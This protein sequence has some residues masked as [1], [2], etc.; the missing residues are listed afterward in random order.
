[1]EKEELIVLFCYIVLTLIMTYPLIFKMNFYTTGDTQAFIWSFWWVKHA[2]FD[3][4]TDLFY[5]NHIFYPI[6]MDLSLYTLTYFNTFFSLPLQL[7][8]DEIVTYNIMF[9]FSFIVSGFGMFLLVRYLTNDIRASFVTGIIF[10]FCPFRFAHAMGHMTVLSTEWIPFYVLY[11]IK[12]LKET[13]KKNAILAGIFLALNALSEWH[14]LLFLTLFSIF[15]LFYYYMKDRKTLLNKKFLINGIV[16]LSVFL[17]ITFPFLF[18]L[19]GASSNPG[20]KRQLDPSIM[21]SADLM[22][23]FVPSEFHPIFGKYVSGIYS[24][25]TGITQENTHF[26]GY[27]VIFLSVFAIFKLW[28]K[29]KIWFFLGI[30]FFVLSLGPVLHIFGKFLYSS[31]IQFGNILRNSGFYLTNIGYDLLN[32]F[33]GIPLPYLFLHYTVPFFKLFRTPGRFSVLVIFSFSVI[34]G[35]S[36]SLLLKKSTYKNLVFIM[37][38]IYKFFF[39]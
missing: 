1:M 9:L 38:L 30:I 23:F 17:L 27:T 4:K 34:A 18:K 14:Y 33:I 13:N 10:A 7:F 20:A 39:A 11:L 15:F 29:T 21:T 24:L 12:T 19:L 2:L 35:Y 28:E 16:L 26:I 25:F 8:F 37:F 22:S 36:L 5:T 3:F 31:P 32:R 6:G